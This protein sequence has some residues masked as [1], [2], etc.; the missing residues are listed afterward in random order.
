MVGPLEAEL[1]VPTQNRKKGGINTDD[2]EGG[3]SHQRGRR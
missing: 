3:G 1:S 2:Q